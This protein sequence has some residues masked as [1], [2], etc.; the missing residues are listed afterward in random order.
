MRVV[1]RCL[2]VTWRRAL[3][4][5]KPG[6]T[7]LPYLAQ[8]PPTS[9]GPIPLQPTS[10]LSY[11]QSDLTKRIENKSFLTIKE[12][13]LLKCDVA[14]FWQ[15]NTDVSSQPT[16]QTKR[17]QTPYNSAAS[18]LSLLQRSSRVFLRR[19]D[20]QLVTRRFGST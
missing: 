14:E 2:A 18:D 8:R 16:Y 12:P 6:R 3:C 13:L 11:V 15:V 4:C 7:S 20:W 1:C 10:A 17:S 9:T 5:V 19:V